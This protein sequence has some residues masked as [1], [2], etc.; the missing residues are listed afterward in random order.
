MSRAL[1]IH[2]GADVDDGADGVGGERV[3]LPVGPRVGLSQ[4]DW[5]SVTVA[6]PAAEPA[7]GPRLVKHLEKWVRG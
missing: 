6:A 5:R 3:R 7:G 1:P 4:G 2:V